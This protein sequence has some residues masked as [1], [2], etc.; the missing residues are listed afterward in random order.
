MTDRVPGAPGQYQAVLSAEALAKMQAGEQFTIT[1][2][3]DDQPITEGTPYSKAAVLP[4]AL[5]KILCPDKEDPTPADAL[6][7]LLP[8]RGGTMTGDI[9]MGNY[10]VSNVNNMAVRSL[11]STF[12]NGARVRTFGN[13][14][15]SSD[16]KITLERGGY[17]AHL[18]VA[19]TAKSDGSL[20]TGCMYFVATGAT[21]TAPYVKKIWDDQAASLVFETTA[22]DNLVVTIPAY[23]VCFAISLD[24]YN[25]STWVN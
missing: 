7:A 4:D 9:D 15:A 14:T 25:V 10:N 21:Q 22:T 20:G 5:A 11:L 12:L 16:K 2:T 8:M 18:F 1:L 6:A 17:S 23:T 24:S 13:N 19:H 3:R